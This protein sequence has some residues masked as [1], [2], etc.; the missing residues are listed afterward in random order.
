MYGND[1]VCWDSSGCFCESHD[2]PEPEL[3]TPDA[4]EALA[5]RHATTYWDSYSSGN[6]L[7][8]KDA[9]L[10][11]LR[12]YADRDAEDLEEVYYEAEELSNS[13]DALAEKY[14][15]LQDKHAAA[16]KLIGFLM[17]EAA[18]AE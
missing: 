8:M 1:D 18:T 3:P 15:E 14:E 2:S 16:L 9:I 11:A 17:L 7:S 12:E 6:A 4:L 5:L 10:A 13:A